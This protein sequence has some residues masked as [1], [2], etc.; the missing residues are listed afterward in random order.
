MPETAGRVAFVTLGCKVNQAESEAIAGELQAA[1]VGC[2]SEA[3]DVVVINTCTVTGE[4]DHKARKAVRRALAL[5]QSPVVVVTGCLAALD[6]DGLRALGDR[7]VVEPEKQLVS[8]RVT[9]VLGETPPADGASRAATETADGAG[10]ARVQLKVED[11]CDAFCAYCIVPHARGAPRSVPLEEVVTR[12]AELRASGVAEVVLTGI[13]I[14]RYSSGTAHLP[15]LLEAVASTGV[16]RVR[17]SSVEPGDVSGRLLEVA[18]ATSAFCPHLHVPLQSGS[19]SVLERMGRP[20]STAAFAETLA[21]ARRAFP[22][23]AISTDIIVGFPGET[24][25]EF[26]ET[27]AFAESQHFSRLHLFRYSPRSGTPAGSM[28]DQVPPS[29]KAERASVLR[30]LGGGLS[31]DYARSL[32]GVPLELLVERT[33]E[34]SVTGAPLAEGTTREYVRLGVALADVEPGVLVPVVIEAL[35][36][37]GTPVACTLR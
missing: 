5:P 23:I 10:R 7:V 6:A 30:A 3:A 15:E 25:S 13:N 18:S 19:D 9:D 37:D 2:G 8:A 27:L 31:A 24:D 1:I 36:A 14:G 4:A 33:S 22:G 12:A 11:G 34:A 32:V 29:V 20:Y 28:S 21:R 35:E 16:P 17:L 26:A